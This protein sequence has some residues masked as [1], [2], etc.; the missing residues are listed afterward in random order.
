[1]SLANPCRPAD[2]PFAS[3]RVEALP[4]RQSTMS[5]PDLL[6]RLDALGGRAALVGCK[7][8]GKTTLMEELSHRLAEPVVLVRIPGS[9]PRPN[10][11]AIRQLPRPVT[12]AH[13]I[14]IDGAE[15]LGPLAWRNILNRTRRAR[16]LVATLH[17]P[18]RLPTLITCTTDPELLRQLVEE[19]AP[20]DA[21]A[22]QPTLDDLFRRHQG[23]IRSCLR[24]LYDVYAGRSSPADHA[25]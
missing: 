10:R 5:W 24:E 22:L 16:R 6:R 17:K 21:T 25:D 19:L 23:N 3:H 8:S 7:G 11:T 15:Q 18:G 13:T 2:N 9:D 1:M 14:L 4:Y 12:T 20:N